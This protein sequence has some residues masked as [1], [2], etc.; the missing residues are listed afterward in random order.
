MEDRM[1]TLHKIRNV[2]KI[3]LLVDFA[4]LATANPARAADITFLCAGALRPAMQELLP[5]F[6]KANGHNVKLAYTNIGTITERVR[7]GDDADLAIVSPQQWESLQKEGKLST[8]T[9]VV[10]GKVGLGVSVKKG[11]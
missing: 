10:I 7:R 6:E 8:G 9:R 4:L 5:E 3:V 11:A 2:M 1:K